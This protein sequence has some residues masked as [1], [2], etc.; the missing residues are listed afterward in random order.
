[1]NEETIFAEALALPAAERAAYLD[2]VCVG[3]PELRQ[4]IEALLQ[5]HD[6]G[7]LLN[8]P[9]IDLD[10][11]GDAATADYHPAIEPGMIIAGRYTLVQKIGEGGMGEVWLA[12][13]TEPVKR[14]VALKL[15]KAGLDSRAV[16]ARFENERQALAMMDH[17][18]IARVLDGGLTP[19]G[20]PFF[21]MELVNG[22]ALSKFCDQAR[23][24]LRERLELFV[25]ICQAVQHA[26]YK[27]IV[28]RDLKPANILVT[29]IDARPVPKVIDFG[30]A[31]ATGGKLTDE[32]LATQFGAIVGT[33]E[34]LSPEQAGYSGL[35]IDTRADIYSLGVILYELLTG[36]RP[37]DAKRL[38]KAAF[39]EMIR[40]IHEEEPSKPSTRLSTD[41]ALPS[42]AALRQTE[43]RKLMALLRGELDWVVM[44]CLE[45]QRER[46]YT[47]ANSLAA[48]IQC[49]LADEPVEARPPSAAYRMSKFLKRHKGPVMAASLLL[50]A[51]LCGI[52][53]TTW[54]LIRADRARA[55]E[56]QRVTERD[57]ALTK[58]TTS[59]DELLSSVARSLLRPLAVQVRPNQ[60]LPLLNDQ[61]IDAL[62]DLAS[63]KDDRLRLRFVEVA[64]GDL[65]STRRLKY[66]AAFALH[67]AAGLNGTRR[68]QVEGLLTKRLQANELP[69]EQQV[70]VALCLAHFGILDRPLARRSAAFLIQ[71]MGK[72]T[73]PYTLVSL[74]HGLLAVVPHLEPKE[75]SCVCGQAAV[76]LTQALGGPTE[77]D[78]WVDLSQNRLAVASHL[79]PKEAAEAAAT[80][81]Q[82]MNKTK[83][84][85]AL[86]ALA[87]G[88]SA[89]APRLEPKEAGEAAAALNQAIPK[90]KQAP[91]LWGPL[92]QD[93]SAI[94]SRQEPKE[95][96]ATLTQAMTKMDNDPMLMASLLALAS[97]L[98][99]KDAAEAAATLNQALTNTTSGWAVEYLAQGLSAVASRLE[100]KEAAQICGQTAATLTQ[101]MNKTTEP[102]ALKSLAMGLSTVASHLEAKEAARAYEQAAATLTQAMNKTTE[103]HALV[104]LAMGLLT[105][106]SHLEAKEAARAYEQ[107]AA[108][109]TQAM[110]KTTKPYDL[111]SL[112]I[113]LSTVASHLEPKQ[114]AQ[115]C[116]QAAAILTQAM[117]KTTE[118][119]DLK[120]LAQG[121]SVTASHLEP[122][123]AAEAAAT[124][125]QAITEREDSP[126]AW[127]FLAE[128]LSAVTAF[129]EP[130]EAAVSLTRALSKTQEWRDLASSLAN[131]L[132]AVA[133]RQEPKEAVSTLT[134]AMSK[135]THP[136]A[137]EI[138]AQGLSAVASRLEPKDAAE[139]A[140]SLTQAMNQTTEPL[141]LAS[142]AQGLSAAASHLEPKDAA[143]A[144][145]QA[146][147]TLTQA[148]N[149]TTKPLYL[150]RL[151]QG[152][153]A[154]ASRLEPKDAAQAY[155][156]AA[157]TLT[158]AMNQTSDPFALE[159][160]AQG[161]S[162]V[163]ARMEL[164]EAAQA[165][166]QAAVTITQEGC[167][168]HAMGLMEPG[169]AA[170]LF[171]Q[172]SPPSHERYTSV[173][174]TVATLGGP[175][176]PFVALALAQPA[177]EPLPP[178]LPPQTLVDILKQPFCVGEP[179][180]LVLEQLGRQYHR[181]FAD[182]W[183]FV[184]YV[185]QHKLA[186][187][188]TT[189]P[190]RPAGW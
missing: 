144:C 55:A 88:L 143:Q 141:V 147:I 131:G 87:R 188:L 6:A 128:S 84:P 164:K 100:P 11:T 126:G 127:G 136:E 72:T 187:D 73:E 174:A 30:V 42:L 57:A 124:L 156:Q 81:N 10:P 98:E 26:H 180:R 108:T 17:P 74:S 122:K 82:A 43:P 158:K 110:N 2:A 58:L 71:A 65:V 162:A 20:Q 145:G 51:L 102:D 23:L 95:G 18:N 77:E 4:R 139:A 80:L 114:A 106:A 32:S 182:Q 5:A 171:R 89:V 181:P 148:M 93:L 121:L 19:T 130:K 21:V 190:Q 94:A 138:L 112:A 120:S 27:G 33:L 189:P 150:A 68:T 79:E 13:Q 142:V 169:L 56:A 134:K 170:V 41:E 179:R 172:P 22:L 90:M 155:A 184:D 75:A 69:P 7:S 28:H 39:T 61:E 70:D 177:L 173:T 125:N 25:P 105:V 59:E 166:G 119:Y 35:D 34:Y 1:M 85:F 175:R 63:S 52:A 40:I 163:A 96:V 183:E 161:L 9:A 67:A 64:L 154:V 60:P 178:P 129:L 133:Y 86:K 53:G 176:L 99:P 167:K 146:T 153:S 66:R 36:L 48:D 24:S 109:L 185:H 149:K 123:A 91:W 47:T 76:I 140:A 44:K 97:R 31:K 37:I 38:K 165:C 107:A 62:W 92:A 50:L 103:P 104:S 8:P 152:V 14:K 151:A 113:G 3:Q 117:N 135:T 168:I 15:I 83:D 78:A 115:M 132:S 16:V 54:G 45:K 29:L 116:G 12:K 118:P 101:A 137:L 160:L 159:F 46:R 186:L 157:A 111:K 49:Y